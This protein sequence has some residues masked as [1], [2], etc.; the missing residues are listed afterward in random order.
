MINIPYP[1][2][3]LDDIRSHNNIGNDGRDTVKRHIPSASR[4]ANIAMTRKESQRTKDDDFF[5]EIVQSKPLP[6]QQRFAIANKVADFS[7]SDLMSGHS[8]FIQYDG[9]KRKKVEPE[10]KIRSNDKVH[11]LRAPS[12]SAVDRFIIPG[13]SGRKRRLR[14]VK[15]ALWRSLRCLDD[16]LEG[17]NV[18]LFMNN[19]KFF[20]IL[21]IITLT[22]QLS[23]CLDQ[24]AQIVANLCRI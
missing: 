16:V 13:E 14:E 5:V 22:W 9:L 21:F 2:V 24:L 8:Q 3:E 12:D 20:E 17:T 19:K 18:P 23:L 6:Q 7:S 15:F 10:V 11:R 4:A 1:L